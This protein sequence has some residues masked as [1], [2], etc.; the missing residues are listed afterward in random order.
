MFKAFEHDEPY[1]ERPAERI[2]I[3]TVDPV[4]RTHVRGPFDNADPDRDALMIRLQEQPPHCRV[5]GFVL[6]PMDKAEAHI[7][8]LDHA[9]SPEGENR[10]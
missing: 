7:W 4:G 5:E 10:P 8:R 9:W 1:R 2:S 3:V 6:G